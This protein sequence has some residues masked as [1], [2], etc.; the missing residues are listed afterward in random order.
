VVPIDHTAPY[1]LLGQLVSE[2]DVLVASAVCTMDYLLTGSHVATDGLV[3]EICQCEDP[4]FDDRNR[5]YGRLPRN[6]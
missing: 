1:V 5:R 6:L 3:K 2:A 4:Y